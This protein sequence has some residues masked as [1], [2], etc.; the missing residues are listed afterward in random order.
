[1]TKVDD[2]AMKIL[3]SP[4]AKLEIRAEA[5][6]K[7]LLLAET[8]GWKPMKVRMYY[9]ANDQNVSETDAH[10]LSTAGQRVLDAALTNPSSVY[11]VGVD[12]GKLYEVVEFC[13][14]GNFRMCR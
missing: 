11:P 1:M 9:L 3:E 12:M 5:W 2:F 6:A 8:W 10:N 4:T 14:A 13:K 7:I